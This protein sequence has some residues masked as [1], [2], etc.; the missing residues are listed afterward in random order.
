MTYYKYISGEKYDSGLLRFATKCVDDQ[1][2]GRISVD[3][4]I[5]L[6][7]EVKDSNMV[8]FIEKSTLQYIKNNYNM[9]KA[10]SEY[11]DSNIKSL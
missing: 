6:F 5:L 11:F 10:S 1:R 9:T 3:D 8:T 7:K 4:C 2:D